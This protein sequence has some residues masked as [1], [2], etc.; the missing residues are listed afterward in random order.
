MIYVLG[1]P[2]ILQSDAVLLLPGHPEPPYAGA[3]LLQDRVLDFLPR[4]QDL[5]HDVH[6]AHPPQTPFT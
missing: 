2:F 5:V 3:G 1:Q 6:P 4:P